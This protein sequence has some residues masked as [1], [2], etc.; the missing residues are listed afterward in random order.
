MTEGLLNISSPITQ[1]KLDE[2]ITNITKQTPRGQLPSYIPYLGNM[3]PSDWAIALVNIHD[4]IY[5]QGNINCKFP[6]MSVIKPFLLLYLLSAIG[7]EQVWKKVGIE[8]SEQPYNSISQLEK[9][10]GWP[11]NPMI[12]SGAI[13]LASLLIDHVQVNNIATTACAELCNWL[14]T[15]AN[16]NLY[17]DE[18]VLKSVRSLPNQT[19]KNI[20]ES[21]VTTGYIKPEHQSE[22]LDIYNQICC[23][24]G[25]ILDLVQLG[26]LL[27]KTTLINPEYSRLVKAL[28]FTSG[29]YEA[30]GRYAVKIGLPMK[31]GVSGIIL[32]IVPQ[33]GAIA[34]Y[35]PPLDNKG[36]SVIGL[37]LLEAI[38]SQLNLSLFN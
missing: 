17:L 25:N 11:R 22:T 31:S 26:M 16:V 20:T 14:N 32:A 1:N 18:A 30:S 9:D 13:C 8:P 12:N 6:L 3:N 19:N 10:H 2:L 37:A 4:D 35:S 15:Q 27:V 23:L 33:Q 7:P 34:C 5:S 36:N 24:S 28:M 29:L 21:L 38:A